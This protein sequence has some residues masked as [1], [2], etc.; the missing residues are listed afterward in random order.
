MRL[1]YRE[2][3]SDQESLRTFYDKES[4]SLDV[5]PESKVDSFSSYLVNEINLETD[6]QGI[7]LYA[8]GVCP[9]TQ[10]QKSKLDPPVGT[11]SQVFVED[12][13]KRIPG[14][15][16]RINPTARWDVHYDDNN[17][18][19]CVGVPTAEGILVQI[20]REMILTLTDNG[21]LKA[22]WLHI[23]LQP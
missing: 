22:M 11:P 5:P 16:K 1:V 23:G 9:H 8:W 4:Y 21:E 20:S 7:I 3:P 2:N 15:S 13:E 18:W 14:A 12:S 19:L 6:E 17:G 10:W